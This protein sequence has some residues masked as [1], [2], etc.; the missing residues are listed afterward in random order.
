MREDLRRSVISMGQKY[1]A[2]REKMIL[3]FTRAESFRFPGRIG[4]DGLL[5]F[6]RGSH[7]HN[8]IRICILRLRAWMS[9]SSLLESTSIRTAVFLQTNQAWMSIPRVAS[10]TIP[11][12]QSRSICSGSR[13]YAKRAQDTLMPN[14]SLR[15]SAI[16]TRTRF[17]FRVKLHPDQPANQIADVVAMRLQ[18]CGEVWIRSYSNG[19]LQRTCDYFSPMAFGGRYKQKHLVYGKAGERCPNACGATIQRSVGERSS[20]LPALPE[21]EASTS[22]IAAWVAAGVLFR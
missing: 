15:E 19:R 1:R 18:W 5:L 3:T 11:H 14:K 22:C 12:D 4:Y 10:A 2:P 9:W 6:P 20:F 16:F 21:D 13:F 17:L 8:N 7:W